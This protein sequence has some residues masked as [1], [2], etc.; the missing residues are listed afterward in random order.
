M[1][2]S[3]RQ[4]VI[5]ASTAKLNDFYLIFEGDDQKLYTSCHE[6]GHGF[7]LPHWD[8]DFFNKDLG[9]CM[10][11]T[12]RP[13]ESSKPDDSNF[14]FLAQLYGG[15]D[16]NTNKELSATEVQTMVRNDPATFIGVQQVGVQVEEIEDVK[17][18]EQIENKNKNKNKYYRGLQ[19]TQQTK[20]NSGRTTDS[21]N[22]SSNTGFFSRNHNRGS[23]N[24][25]YRD[26]QQQQQKQQQQ[27]DIPFSSSR[28]LLDPDGNLS[29]E[30]NSIINSNIISNNN[31]NQRRTIRSRR[32][33]AATAE[34]EVHLIESD[35]F[36]EGLIVM[37]H[38]LLVRDD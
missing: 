19:N 20:R 32:I 25:I 37:Q 29:G 31:I 2:L 16:V 23:D 33:L 7:G 11:Y 10:D 30:N 28:L 1:L 13:K 21:T 35:E 12:Q 18:E 27:H 4:N 9:N 22:D 17:E 24:T 34:F 6:L 14:L 36:P 15:R 5:V 3:P 26:L 38:Y 8:E